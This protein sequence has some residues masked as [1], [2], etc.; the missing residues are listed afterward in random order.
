[1]LTSQA[2]DAPNVIGLYRSKGDAR[3]RT[4]VTRGEPGPRNS[5]T[6]TEVALRH[7]RGTGQP[8][9]RTMRSNAQLSALT[10]TTKHRRT[11]EPARTPR[12]RP[13]AIV[14][15]GRA[16]HASS[17]FARPRL[18]PPRIPALTS[19]CGLRSTPLRT[20]RDRHSH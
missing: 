4:S 14:T 12:D 20:W 15:C 19:Q 17:R 13:R 7:V 6:V 18:L 3:R 9:P 5:R 16:F 8:G 11:F 2:R 10:A 1:M